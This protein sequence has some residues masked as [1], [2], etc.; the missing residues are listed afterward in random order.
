MFSLIIYNIGNKV[1][2]LLYSNSEGQVY[3]LSHL[4]SGFRENS[5]PVKR[6]AC[7]LKVKFVT[8][9]DWGDPL[10]YTVY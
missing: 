7:V 3:I 1:I 8:S 2:C 4:F 5:D 6:V 10:G 9:R